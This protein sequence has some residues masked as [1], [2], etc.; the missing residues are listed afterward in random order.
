MEFLELISKRKHMIS[1]CV[2]LTTATSALPEWFGVAPDVWPGCL[3]VDDDC[4]GEKAPK[5]RAI[6]SDRHEELL[7]HWMACLRHSEIKEHY[8]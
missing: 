5:G 3:G 8:R 7:L 6:W 4:G 2:G 1:T